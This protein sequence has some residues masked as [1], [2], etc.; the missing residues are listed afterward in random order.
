MSDAPED[1]RREAEALRAFFEVQLAF[2]GRIAPRFAE[3]FEAACL[4]FTN[5]HFRLGLGKV[6]PAAPSEAWR[7]YASGLA[8]RTD[9][10]GRV[11]WTV[12]FFQTVRPVED[13][14]RRF[15]CFNFEMLADEPDVVR[16][17]F[18]NRDSGGDV[19]PLARAKLEARLADLAAM[20][21]VVRAEHPEA[22]RVR[23]SSWLYNLEA[24]RRLFPPAYVASAVRPDRVRLN[25]T[26]SWGQVL[27]FRG[28]AKPEV[29]AALLH[30]AADPG[31]AAPCEAF[32]LR[33]LAVECAVGDFYALYGI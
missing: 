28:C 26:S 5:L 19:G 31:L 21:A 25:G 14:K 24:Y 3:S 18:N 29:C 20:F 27:D 33:P 16:I 22:R 12:A 9:L 4:E 2:A 1:R 23:G 11:D 10:A 15:G 6:D 30:K 17:H 7:D 13:G 32:P 8:Q